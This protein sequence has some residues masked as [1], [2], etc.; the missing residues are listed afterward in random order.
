MLEV[1]RS[2]GSVT[3]KQVAQ[4]RKHGFLD[5]PL[6]EKASQALADIDFEKNTLA[7]QTIRVS[8]MML[9]AAAFAIIALY[10]SGGLGSVAQFYLSLIGKGDWSLE[11]AAGILGIS[12]VST[13]IVYPVY[14]SSI[15]NLEGAGYNSG[16]ASIL[17]S[18]EPGGGVVLL[19]VIPPYERMT[20]LQLFGTVLI[21]ATSTL[22][23]SA[24][25]TK[26]P[27]RRFKAWFERTWISLISHES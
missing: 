14:Y 19:A 5:S 18:L 6:S 21:L 8:F 9:F 27:F 26:R 23:V 16:L 15:V 12:I 25:M 20:A 22:A 2:G 1:L 4:L 11:A 13:A 3:S 24:Y 10:F 7:G 17:Q